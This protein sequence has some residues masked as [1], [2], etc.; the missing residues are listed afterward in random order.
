MPI[1][2]FQ[3]NRATPD[4]LQYRCK[5]CTKKA[6]A[7]CR[8]ARG[9]LWLQKINPW[10]KRPENRDRVNAATRAR[11]AARP[12]DVKREERFRWDLSHKY[13][14]TPELKQALIDLQGG[15]CSICE[16]P[17]DIKRATDHDHNGDYVRGMLCKTCNSG[18]G[19]FKDNS[20]LLRKAAKYLDDCKSIAEEPTEA[21]F[22]EAT[23][24]LEELEVLNGEKESK[25]SSIISGIASTQ[26]G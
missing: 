6:S 17:I 10:A 5:K 22:E 13:G 14:L 9:H 15:I 19:L 16:Y 25:E 8:A 20:K 24:I 12:M 18:L 23:Q 7:I 2:S 26:K 21:D 11:Q 1:D 4:G 3:K